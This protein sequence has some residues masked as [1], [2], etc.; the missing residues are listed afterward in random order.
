MLSEQDREKQEHPNEPKQAYSYGR[1]YDIHCAPP[2]F[3]VYHELCPS[4][5]VKPC[6]ETV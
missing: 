5:E 1:A 2:F 6:Q 3:P 4:Q